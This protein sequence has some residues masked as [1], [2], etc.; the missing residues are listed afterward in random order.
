MSRQSH[1]FAFSPHTNDDL[2][3]VGVVLDDCTRENGC[4]LMLPGSH[5]WPI[6]DHH[7]D[8]VFVGAIDLEREGVDV[9]GAVPVTVGAGGVTL[10]HTWMLHASA[11][12]TST[13]P[14]RLLPQLAAVDSWPGMGVS[15]LVQCDSWVLRSQPPTRY[16]VAEM[17]I[18]IPLPKHERQGRIYTIQ[19]LFRPKRF[20]GAASR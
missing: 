3:A 14:R 20:A 19:T 6:L 7:Q 18:R 8:G 2:L 1:A 15:D 11:P 10:H 16:R 13:L 12:N 17:H 4:L 5:R 9:P